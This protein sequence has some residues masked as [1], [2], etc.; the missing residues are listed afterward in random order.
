MAITTPSV[1]RFRKRE[2]CRSASCTS[3][4]RNLHTPSIP[5][6]RLV[7]RIR[8]PSRGAQRRERRLSGVCVIFT[9]VNKTHTRRSARRAF[10]SRDGPAL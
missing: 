2:A 8:S 5:R 9:R 3:S 7:L 1:C 10:H 6:H 4:R